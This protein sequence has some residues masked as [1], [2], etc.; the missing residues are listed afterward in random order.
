MSHAA[1]AGH[2]GHA[3]HGGGL[4]DAHA[5]HGHGVPRSVALA[6]DNIYLAHGAGAGASRMLMG[7]A[8]VGILVTVVGGF[9]VS[10]RHGLAA[11]HTG[12]MTCLAICLGSLFF[13][14]AFHLVNAGWSVTIR[15]QFENIMVLTPVFAALAA[16]S[17]FLDALFF[18]GSLWIWMNPEF[19]PDPLLQ[20]KAAYLNTPFFLVRAVVYVLVWTFLSQSMWRFSTTQ[21]QTGDRWLT[22]RARRMSTYGMLAFALTTAF[23]SFDWL[24]GVDFHFF[25]T[26]WGVIYFAA[27]AFSSAAA[28]ILV[29]AV[30]TARGKMK[31]CCTS[32]HFHD[33]GKLLLSFTV[34]WAYVSF[35]QYFLIWYAN[36]PEETAYFLSRKKDGWEFMFYFLCLGH[37]GVP[38]LFLIFRDTKRIPKLLALGAAWAILVHAADIVYIVRPM[39]YAGLPADQ[40]GGMLTWVIDFAGIIGMLALLASLVIRKVSAGPLVPLQDPRLDEALSHKNYV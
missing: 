11:F 15:R 9:V 6:R 32:E 14:M 40:R 28:V 37:F 19:H 22:A 29:L 1:S 10:G 8:L 38:F 25:S 24:M 16:L 17:P 39:V 7:V 23:A 26:M 20:A 35:S 21:D 31:Y 3:G 36:I 2:A 12:A 30:L 34:F 18:R 33:L 4:A 13:V 5:E 27:S